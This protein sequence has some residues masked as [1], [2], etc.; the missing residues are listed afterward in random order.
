MTLQQVEAMVD[1]ARRKKVFLMEGM[2]SR[3]FPIY[4]RI[5]EIVTDGI[6]GDVR[7]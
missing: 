4:Y 1:L 3:F 6:I 2:W 7:V 5:R